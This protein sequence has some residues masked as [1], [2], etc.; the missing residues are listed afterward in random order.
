MASLVGEK[1]W[2]NFKY[3]RLPTFY[4]LCGKLGNDDKHCLAFTDRQNT[5]KQY[6][7]WL[8]ARGAFKGNSG[9]Q[10]NTQRG[11]LQEGSDDIT[12]ENGQ[13]SVRH[14]KSPWWMVAEVVQAVVVFKV[15]KASHT[16]GGDT[17]ESQRVRWRK[18]AYMMMR[19]YTTLEIDLD[20]VKREL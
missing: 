12:K 5:P 3:E 17:S 15:Q 10:R 8:K 14:S 6:G 11:S 7:E 19:Q 9:R 2:V 20:W 13:T 1:F 18:M 4:F 16:W